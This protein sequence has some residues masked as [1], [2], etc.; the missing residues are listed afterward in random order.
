MHCMHS[1]SSFI[2]GVRYKDK[3]EHETGRN[4]YENVRG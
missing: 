2:V 1:L 4:F 3:K